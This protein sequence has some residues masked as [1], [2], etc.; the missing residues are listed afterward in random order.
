MSTITLFSLRFWSFSTHNALK[1]SAMLSIPFP[2][3]QGSGSLTYYHLVLSSQ[4]SNCTQNDIMAQHLTWTVRLKQPNFILLSHRWDHIKEAKTNKKQT[5]IRLDLVAKKL[6]SKGN[7]DQIS[8]FF[9][10]QTFETFSWKETKKF[11]WD[12]AM[13]KSPHKNS[14]SRLNPTS[15]RFSIV[16]IFLTKYETQHFE[17]NAT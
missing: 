7:Q 2:L 8:S 12:K 16:S 1:K 6:H 5:K 13:N 9:H 4:F 3:Y 11:F 17:N 10:A 14:S 15:N